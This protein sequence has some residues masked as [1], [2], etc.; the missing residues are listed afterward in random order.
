MEFPIINP[1]FCKHKNFVC[2]NLI[3][4]VCFFPDTV[5]PNAICLFSKEVLMYTKVYVVGSLALVSLSPCYHDPPTISGRAVSQG[6]EVTLGRGDSAWSILTGWA[7]H[8]VRLCEIFKCCLFLICWLH[9]SELADLSS[10]I[11][12]HDMG[13]KGVCSQKTEYAF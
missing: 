7:G 10:I 4:T 11:I 13:P 9:W 2:I 12:K 3:R 1:I 5:C 6:S 8:L